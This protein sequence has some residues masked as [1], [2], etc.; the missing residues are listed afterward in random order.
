MS[1]TEKQIL[2]HIYN[3]YHKYLCR[4]AEL[5]GLR[6]K[7]LAGIMYRETAGGLSPLLDK[8]GPEGRGDN[9]HG[10][11]L[12][13]IDDR[14]WPGYIN[15]N[16]WQDPESNINFGAYVLHIKIMFF[17]LKR[18]ILPEEYKDRTE[19]LGIAAYNAGEGRV[20]KAIRNGESP[21]SVTAH[22]NYLSAVLEYGE[23]YEALQ[24]ALTPNL[25]LN[26]NIG[27]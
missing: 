1:L 17:T 21:D 8:I 20:L 27:G 14:W 16:T 5:N 12:M 22:G 23:K 4:A 10:R 11:G 13:Q 24:I 9:G 15:K 25:E 18:N 6:P 7:I 3:N 2:E 26:T 19:E